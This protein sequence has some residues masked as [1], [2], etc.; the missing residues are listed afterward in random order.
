MLSIGVSFWF[1]CTVADQ[2]FGRPATTSTIAAEPRPTS[3]RKAHHAVPK[4]FRTLHRTWD[5]SHVV[6]PP[7]PRQ[8]G[9]ARRCAPVTCAGRTRPTVIEVILRIVEATFS[10]P[11]LPTFEPFVDEHAVAQFLQIA[12][13]RV[14]EMARKR[15][16]PAHPIG[17]L[18]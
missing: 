7:Q 14:L 11:K 1:A 4:G 2:T 12:A 17:N 10:Q 3:S 9:R 6:P 5:D 16:L 8:T 15:E 18:R 13:R